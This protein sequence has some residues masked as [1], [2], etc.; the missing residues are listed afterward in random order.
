MVGTWMAA[1]LLM[2]VVVCVALVLGGRRPAELLVATGQQVWLEDP[3]G[4]RLP[5]G[6]VPPGTYVLLVAFQPGD[7]ERMGEVTLEPGAR[8]AL[9]CDSPSHT[10]W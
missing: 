5:A 2:A 6:R 3:H 7:P 9:H 1:G 4:E 8:H 10:C